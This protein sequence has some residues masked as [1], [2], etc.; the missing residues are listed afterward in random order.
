MLLFLYIFF[1]GPLKQIQDV[2]TTNWDVHCEE[3]Q[4]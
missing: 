4:V 2:L 3:Y 1:V